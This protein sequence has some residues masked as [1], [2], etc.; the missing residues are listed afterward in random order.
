MLQYKNKREM[1]KYNN[2]IKIYPEEKKSIHLLNVHICFTFFFL[3]EKGYHWFVFSCFK[4]KTSHSNKMQ[5][6]YCSQ[7]MI[8]L[9]TMP[10]NTYEAK[11]LEK[12]SNL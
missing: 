1:I 9:N 8:I 2:I 4:N 3:F 10:H 5:I 11:I 6:L 7:R 12:S